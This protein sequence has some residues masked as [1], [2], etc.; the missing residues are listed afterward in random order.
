MNIKLNYVYMLNG[1][2]FYLLDIFD[3]SWTMG[4]NFGGIMLINLI[5]LGL[6]KRHF[7]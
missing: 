1:V 6:Q 7:Q 4:L 5:E 3:H 2:M